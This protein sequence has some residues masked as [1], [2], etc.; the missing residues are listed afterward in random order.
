[1]FTYLCHIIL[2]LN[3]QLGYSF[4]YTFYKWINMSQWRKWMHKYAFIILNIFKCTFLWHYIHSVALYTFIWL[5]NHQYCPS[6]ILTPSFHT[7]T[8]YPLNYNFPWPP[9]NHNFTFCLYEFDYSCMSS[10]FCSVV[11]NSL[12]PHGLQP[13]SLLCPWNF[14]GKKYWSGLPFPSP[15]TTL[16]TLYKE[17]SYNLCSLCL[18]YF[19]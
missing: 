16:G 8:V 1:M 19:S 9:G 6:P 18:A 12:W 15:L 5:G 11:S 7:K 17:E 2:L 14:P 3:L 4:T 13:A 10:C